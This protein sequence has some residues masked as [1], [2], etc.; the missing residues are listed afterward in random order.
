MAT[1]LAQEE[2]EKMYS[3]LGGKPVKKLLATHW[4]R[5]VELMYSAE[6]LLELAQDPEVASPNI[7]TLPTAT[8][9]EGVGIVEAM[10][11]ILTHHYQ[12]DKNGLVTKAN[13]IVGTT[14]NQCADLNVHQARGSEADPARQGG[15]TG[16]AE[17]GGDGL[18]AVRSVLLLRDALAA[19]RNAVDRRSDQRRRRSHSPRRPIDD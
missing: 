5:L 9:E 14:N 2:Y 15:R 18:P 17:H 4:A 1:P 12:T 8:P 19:R 11:G 16:T 13:L 7:R 3:T 6:R 10:R